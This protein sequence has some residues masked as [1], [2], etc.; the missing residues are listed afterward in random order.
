MGHSYPLVT[1]SFFLRLTLTRHQTNFWPASI[2]YSLSSDSCLAKLEN[3]AERTSEQ[4]S[5]EGI[6][7]PLALVSPSA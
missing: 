7:L 4:Q 1:D 2:A 3:Q 5:R 6:S